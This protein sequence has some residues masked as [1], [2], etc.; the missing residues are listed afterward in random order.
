MTL[1]PFMKVT[2]HAVLVS[3]RM[4]AF[5]RLR[6]IVSGQ[7]YWVDKMRWPGQFWLPGFGAF[8]IFKGVLWHVSIGFDPCR[9]RRKY[10]GSMFRHTAVSFSL[11]PHSILLYYFNVSFS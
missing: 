5:V 9:A 6:L 7:L 4:V 2:C 11:A 3:V 1:N 8:C 10:W